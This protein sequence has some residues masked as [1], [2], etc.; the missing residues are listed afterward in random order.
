M[1]APMFT[2]S[3]ARRERIK[4]MIGLAGP[5]GSGKTYSALQIAFGITGDWKKIAVIDTENGSALYYADHKDFG[6]FDHMPFPHDIQD[7]YHP[8]NYCR[9]IEAVEAD[10][11][12]EVVIID[13]VSHEWEGRGGAID[14]VDGIGSGFSAWKIVTPLHNDFIDKM[15]NSR[16]HVIGC[17]R[18]KTDYVVEKNDKGKNA[19]R[20]IGLKVNQREGTD[21]EF[22]IVFD[23]SITHFATVSKDRTSLFAG[24]GPFKITA[25][26]GRQLLEWAKSGVE[27]APK[28]AAQPPRTT[29][30]APKAAPDLKAAPP[31]ADPTPPAPPARKTA[32]IFDGSPGQQETVKAILERQKVPVEQWDQICS[33]MI[34]KP[35]TELGAIIKKVKAAADAFHNAPTMDV[36]PSDEAPPPEPEA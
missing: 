9:A 11:N 17:M 14:I 7:G 32:T 35:S 8:H 31:P 30:A 24:K 1:T 29:P 34:G 33:E 25:A 27:P 12:I 36:P 26:A 10:P 4:L 23:I 6:P 18:T 13:S 15:R 16:L 5:S 3:T 20:K 19:P 2:K 28:P 22:G 21:Y